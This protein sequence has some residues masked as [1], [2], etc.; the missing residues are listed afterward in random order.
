MELPHNKTF[1]QDIL[2][3]AMVDKESLFTLL[4]VCRDDSFYFHEHVTIFKIISALHREGTVVDITTIDGYAN[5]KKIQGKYSGINYLLE[6]T[7]GHATSASHH[8]KCLE[9][10][11]MAIARRLHQIGIE[12]Q[13]RAM[14]PAFESDKVSTWLNKSILEAVS[15]FK[16]DNSGSPVYRTAKGLGIIENAR[17][18][19]RYGIRTG[20]IDF[21]DALNLLKPKELTI[22]AARPGMGKTT[23]GL[24]VAHNVSKLEGAVIFYQCEMSQESVSLRELSMQTGLY[25]SQLNNAEKLTESQYNEVQK[26]AGKIEQTKVY[27][28]YTPGL[29]LNNF[30][31]SIQ[32]YCAK[33][34]VKLVLID[35]L[36]IMGYNGKGN[37]NEEIG[38]TVRTIRK[39]AQ[40]LGVHVIL[41][42]QLSREVEKRDDKRPRLS[43]LRDSGEI[44]QE[45][46]NVIFLL[47]PEYYELW[48]ENTAMQNQIIM[49][50]GKGRN[51]NPGDKILGCDVARNRIFDYQKEASF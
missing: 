31:A 8:V 17:K 44:E 43:D 13:A 39:I 10:E 19:N 33:M 42:S 49:I 21:D 15:T 22:V 48:R 2:R 47:R 16:S 24:Q 38:H 41:F 30:R 26:A 36:Q 46:D 11:E 5:K 7:N 40:E 32:S 23:F 50:I 25:V 12:L 18:G 6:L 27:V 51:V 28:E 29:T 20:L 9:V 1:E 35:Y 4:E 45:A 3:N 14:N 34:A 37:R